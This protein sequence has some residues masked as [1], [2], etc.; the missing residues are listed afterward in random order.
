MNLASFEVKFT[1]L[2]FARYVQAGQE[3]RGRI[4]ADPKFSPRMRFKT[5]SK[6]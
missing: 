6:S 2:T 1:K 5:G 3:Q 4:W